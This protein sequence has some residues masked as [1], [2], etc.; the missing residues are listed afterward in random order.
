MVKRVTQK[1][2]ENAIF[3]NTIYPQDNISLE[4]EIKVVCL[5]YLTDI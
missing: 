5:V 1:D 2:I 4:Y 3:N